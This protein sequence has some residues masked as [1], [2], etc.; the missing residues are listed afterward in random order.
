MLDCDKKNKKNE[1]PKPNVLDENSP[2]DSNK[3]SRAFPL[4]HLIGGRISNTC[5]KKWH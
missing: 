1:E 3:N 2:S 4:S 5:I